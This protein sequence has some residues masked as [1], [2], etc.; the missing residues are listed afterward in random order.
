MI[1]TK[2]SLKYVLSMPN[3]GTHYFQVEMQIS[4]FTLKL[5]DG[6]LWIVMPVWTPGS[7]LVREFSRNVLDFRAFDPTAGI[8]IPARK[9]SKNKWSVDAGALTSFV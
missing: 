7:Y 9:V 1:E 8:E 2:F 3:P 5:K 4:N 6:A